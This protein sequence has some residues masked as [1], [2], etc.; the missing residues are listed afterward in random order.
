MLQS[1]ISGLTVRRAFRY[2]DPAGTTTVTA[3]AV[4][5][6]VRVESQDT[7]SLG[8]DRVVLAANPVVQITR[9]GIFRL[10]FL[11][12]AGF[13]VE[14]VSGPAL[15][16]WTELKSAEGRVITL[17]LTGKTEGQQQF[18]L[19]VAGPGL[20][21]TNN[22]PVP[23]L[24]LREASKQSGTLLL[25]PEQGLRLQ[26]A[27]SEGMTQL[28]PQKSGIKQKGVLAFRV[29]QTARS[30]S[31]N[32]EQV[33]PWVQVT[34]LQHVTLA[35]AQAKV[36]ANLHY[37]IENTGLKTLR[38]LVPTNAESVRF[39]G[40][41]VADFLP[42]P[43]DVTNALQGWQIK[44]HRRVIGSWMLQVTWQNTLPG[45]APAYTLRGVQAADVNLQRGFVTVQTGGRLEVHVDAASESLQPAEWQSIPRALHQGLPAQAA[46]YTFRLVE[47]DF[48]LPLRL[49][50]HEPAKLLPARVNAISITSVISDDGHMLAQAQL[51]ILPG[52]KRLLEV[53]LPPGARFWFAFVNRNGVWP[54][55]SKQNQVLIPLEKQ[56][57]PD[58]AIP[59]EIFFASRVGDSRPRSL[60]LELLA[61]KFDLPLENITWRVLLNEK[62]QVRTWSD[63][64]QFEQERVVPQIVSADLD[65]YLQTELY[66]QQLRTKQAEERLASANSALQQGD[67]LQARRDFQAAYGLSTHDAAFNE[68][69]RVQLHNIKLQQALVGLNVRQAAVAGE[70][71]PL[72][73]KLR[74][75]RNR[76]EPNYTQ[77]DAKEIIERNTEDENA[78]FM[79]LA[80]RIIQ[81]QNAAVSSPTALRANVPDQGRSLTFKRAV[82]VDSPARGLEDPFESLH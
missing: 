58:V 44:L 9:A 54:W 69:A 21:A 46:N 48:S 11:M 49:E 76:K 66:Q 82:L 67:P 78:A 1:Q 38:V 8:E 12:P 5:P 7:I 77:Q 70:A 13:D 14:S 81:Q 75:L 15:S 36:A 30:L 2:S 56:T 40:D 62:W 72:A 55:R 31:L 51:E 64:L 3:S 41:Q 6:D 42:L 68:D 80:E 52:D 29:L 10:S 60:D 45:Q 50:R 22:W 27:N 63:S 71:S 26:V 53:T 35:E 37:H 43:G 57:R 39:A 47:A 79:R 74:E 28:D 73:G 24:L 33:D 4:Q 32:I 34:S 18:A 61:P 16:H 19:S 59:V 23:Q 25:V 20:K 65:N 17:H